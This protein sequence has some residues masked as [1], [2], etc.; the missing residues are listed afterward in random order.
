MNGYHDFN[1]S[2]KVHKTVP[3]YVVSFWNTTL[4]GIQAFM[5]HFYG[6]NFGEHCIESIFSPIVYITIFSSFETIVLAGVNGSYIGKSDCI[7]KLFFFFTV[8]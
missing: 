7:Q 4:M 8:F 6:P 2:I 5:Q 3:F 1:R